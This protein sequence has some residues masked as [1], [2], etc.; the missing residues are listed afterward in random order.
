VILVTARPDRFVSRA[1]VYTAASRA[2]AR[3]TIIGSDSE[4]A[5]C[6]RRGEKPRRTLLAPPEEPGDPEE[7]VVF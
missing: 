4:L 7:L 2:R 5:A 3:L 1:S 6:A